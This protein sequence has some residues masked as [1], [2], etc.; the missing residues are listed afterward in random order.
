M[1]D[2][3]IIFHELSKGSLPQE[4][5]VEL[6]VKY[7][8][9]GENLEDRQHALDLLNGEYTQLMVNNYADL[10]VE[11]D[12]LQ[13]CAFAVFIQSETMMHLQLTLYRI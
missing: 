11:R 3:K 12:K 5:I 6:A 7:L 2:K 4:R 13:K 9:D 1:I 10:V 8:L